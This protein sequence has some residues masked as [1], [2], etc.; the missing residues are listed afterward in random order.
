M[1][2]KLKLLLVDDDPDFIQYVKPMIQMVPDLQLKKAFTNPRDALVYLHKKRIDILLL[3]IDMPLLN[4]FDLMKQI[5]H[6]IKPGDPSVRPLFV[7]LCSGY[8]TNPEDCF[9]HQAA[10]YI[11]K[12]LTLEKL[13][14]V[15]NVIRQ[16]IMERSVVRNDCTSKESRQA[17]DDGETP[18][19]YSEEEVITFQEAEDI[20]GVKRW[21]I[22][23]MRK[24]GELT[25]LENDGQKRLLRSEVLAKRDS[26]SVRKGKV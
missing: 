23:Q 2:R 7:V 25:D 4:G 26:Y 1:N 20:L 13:I 21:K 17:E 10:Y 14:E 8:E 6:L 22:Y 24:K 16:K 9:K 19:T 12:S 11:Q 15:K 3:D 18:Q 5:Q